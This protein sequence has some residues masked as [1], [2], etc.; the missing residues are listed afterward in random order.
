MSEGAAASGPLAVPSARLIRAAE[1]HSMPWKNGGGATTEICLH[2][3][4]AGLEDFGWR[5]SIA[6]VASDGPFSVFTGVDR[7]LTLLAGEGLW[8]AIGDAAPVL[9]VRDSAPLS[10]PADVPTRATLIGPPVTDLNV[11]TRQGAWRHAVARQVFGDGAMRVSEQQST[12][13]SVLWWCHEGSVEVTSRHGAARLGPHDAWLV[14]NLGSAA[15]RVAA[16]AAAV[17]FRVDLEISPV[18][19]DQAASRPSCQASGQSG[20]PA[21]Q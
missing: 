3:P 6:T 20:E 15:W 18:S 8:L 19:A 13:S 9:L 2:P 10:F 4:G 11:M 17:L 14:E 7:T 21:P 1:C 12:A 16:T 5:V